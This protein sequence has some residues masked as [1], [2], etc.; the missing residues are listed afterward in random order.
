MCQ[1]IS[2]IYKKETNLTMRCYKIGHYT[3]KY[4]VYLQYLTKGSNENAH[5]NIA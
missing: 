4:V 5:I 1:L 3:Y 2:Q